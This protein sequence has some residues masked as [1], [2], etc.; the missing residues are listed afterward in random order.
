MR[1]VIPF[2]CLI[3]NRFWKHLLAL[4]ASLLVVGGLVAAACYERVLA[5][6][7]G[8]GIPRLFTCEN[9]L[10]ARW[11]ATILLFVSG[12]LA[13]LVWWVRKHSERDFGGEFRI[14][15]WVALGLVAASFCVDTQ[16]PQ[17]ASASL[18][19]THPVPGIARSELLLWLVPCGLAGAFLIWRMDRD[20]RGCRSSLITLRLAT[21]C[22]AATVAVQSGLISAIPATIVRLL[23][24]GL[25]LCASALLFH[26]LLLHARHVLYEDAEAPP[27][28]AGWLRRIAR[29]RRARRVARVSDAETGETAEKSRPRRLGRFR[30][31][32][33]RLR[34]RQT[35]DT[36]DQQPEP[37]IAVSDPPRQSTEPE[38]RPRSAAPEPQPR[39]KSGD[40]PARVDPAADR[41]E[42]LRGLSKKERRRLRK[43][44]REA[45][46]AQRS[47]NPS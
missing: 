12:Q 41:N 37:D 26:S 5:T 33:L 32:R 24:L 20:M 21:V 29:L 40:P 47:Q 2:R 36:P 43:Q 23:L 7:A 28:R 11:L 10:V 6:A 30:L 18:I 15:K 14:W 19:A 22:L 46:R 13:L 4:M 8:P 31:P 38:A 25:P 42:A 45:E 27:R 16:A 3:S 1:T 39:S 17:L 35:R 44:W 9:P 34:R